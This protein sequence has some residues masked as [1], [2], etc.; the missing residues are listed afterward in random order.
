MRCVVEQLGLADVQ[1]TDWISHLAWTNLY[2]VSP[3]GGGN[4]S[5]RLCDV[6]FRFCTELLSK[7]LN[8]WNPKRILMLTGIGW[9]K[10]FLDSLG[11]QLSTTPER[12]FVEAVGTVNL[13]GSARPTRLIVA[14]HPQG[15]QEAPFVDEIR[16]SLM[17]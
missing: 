9:A 1:N 12:A 2:K 13:P 11:V 4:P 10:P 16:M 15:K 6:Q 17:Q 8:Q 14:K 5:S 7:E 3:F